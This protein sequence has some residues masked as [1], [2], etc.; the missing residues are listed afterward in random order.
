MPQ[1]AEVCLQSTGNFGP[2][3]V[4]TAFSLTSW[5][6]NHL[7]DS[8]PDTPI[9]FDIE[10][11]SFNPY[12]FLDSLE[13]VDLGQPPVDSTVAEATMGHGQLPV[14]PVVAPPTLHP[15]ADAGLR[16]FLQS[17]GLAPPD[18]ADAAVVEERFRDVAVQTVDPRIISPSEYIAYR[19][20][21]DTLTAA[22]H[23]AL[24]VRG[25]T[26]LDATALADQTAIRLGLP[27]SDRPSWDALYRMAVT[28]I[29]VERHLQVRLGEI[30]AASTVDPSGGLAIASVLVDMLARQ[31]RPWDLGELPQ[32]GDSPELFA[33]MPPATD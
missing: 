12:A 4:E 32:P 6:S 31:R 3:P 17:R 2:P 11:E 15:V 13:H 24:L 28:S 33:I 18:V 9:D 25:C 21:F 23:M 30:L 20:S 22:T 19:Q 29:V 26:S 10:P 8:R 14:D 27:V 16:R 1:A 5:C 7:E